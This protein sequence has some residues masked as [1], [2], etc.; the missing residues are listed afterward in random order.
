MSLGSKYKLQETGVSYLDLLNNIEDVEVAM[1]EL[2]QVECPVVHSFSPGLYMR[3][4]SIPAGT[5]AIGHHQNFEHMNI[6]L[7]GKV[8][9]LNEDGTTSTLTAPMMFTG[10]P[11]RKIGYISE[12]VV[13][14]NVYPTEEQDIEK[15]EAHYLTKTNDWN[16]S[17]KQIGTLSTSASKDDYV[18]LIAELGLTEDVVREE[19]ENKDNMIDLPN[20]SYKIKLG[21]STIEGKGL[22]ATAPIEE[23]EVIAPARIGN[24]RTIAGR[25]T[26]H[27]VTPNARMCLAGATNL[28]L[29]AI[30]NIGGC[31]GGADGEEITISYRDTLE[32]TSSKEYLCQQQSQP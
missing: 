30:K 32:L 21:D 28:N 15:L 27:S 5:F 18:K 2:P 4:I 23:G 20:G 31:H 14:L 1:M 6:F 24:M 29:I 22:F 9:V 16:L 12:D 3:Q 7:K 10:K 8:T 17:T 13:W 11:G 26:N 25:Y 19:V